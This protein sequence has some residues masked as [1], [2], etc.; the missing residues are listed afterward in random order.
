[1]EGVGNGSLLLAVPTAW[2]FAKGG[3]CLFLGKGRR[4][5]SQH[6]P[7]FSRGVLAWLGE[8]DEGKGWVPPC[9]PGF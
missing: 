3:R 5:G 7:L 6:S 4:P 8:R 9:M 2:R 1:M